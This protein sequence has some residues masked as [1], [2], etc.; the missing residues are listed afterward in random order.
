MIY[1]YLHILSYIVYSL[2]VIIT[3]LPPM[4]TRKK[5]QRHAE[6]GTKRSEQKATME[7]ITNSSTSSNLNGL[8]TNR[9][10]Y[11]IDIEYNI[12]IYILMGYICI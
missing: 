6:L 9:Y 5:H 3:S 10:R 2:Q 4:S 11:S 12:Y 8:K 1:S 7:V